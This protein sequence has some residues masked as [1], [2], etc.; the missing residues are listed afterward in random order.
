MTTLSE[1]TPGQTARILDVDLD[2]HELQRLMDM[3]FIEDTT[4]KMVRNAPLLD[5][6]DVEVRGYMAAIRRSEAQQIEVEIL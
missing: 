5:P 4:V 2:G 1:L 3:G 6:I